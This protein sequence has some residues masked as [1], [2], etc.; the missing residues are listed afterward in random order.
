M[1][2]SRCSTRG[3]SLFTTHTNMDDDLDNL[4]DQ[5]GQTYVSCNEV[6]LS[7]STV[8]G[9]NHIGIYR[10]STWSLHAH[11]TVSAPHLIYTQE[12]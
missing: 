1:S 10:R 11:P 12:V 6:S 2:L 4:G 9:S 8:R 3:L 5:Y 7:F